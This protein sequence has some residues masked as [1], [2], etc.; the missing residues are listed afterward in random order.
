MSESLNGAVVKLAETVK[1]LQS[2]NTA[3]A[4]L[5]GFQAV[6][7]QALSTAVTEISQRMQR[8]EQKNL[9]LNKALGE[10]R[11]KRRDIERRLRALEALLCHRP[12]EVQ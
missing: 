12:A 3:N 11:Q 8:A 10:E 9:D 5:Y 1:N 4:Q 2:L 7:I 6:T